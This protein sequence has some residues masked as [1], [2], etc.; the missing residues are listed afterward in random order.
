MATIR[1]LHIAAAFGDH[2]RFDLVFSVTIWAYKTHFLSVRIIFLVSMPTC[3][4]EANILEAF[5]ANSHGN[6]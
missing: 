2:R 3:S 5:L 4:N 1:T 6:D